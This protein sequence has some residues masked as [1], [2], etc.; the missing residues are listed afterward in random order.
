MTADPIDI[1]SPEDVIEEATRQHAGTAPLDAPWE[2]TDRGGAEWAIAKIRQARRTWDEE[3]CAAHA[4][5]DALEEEIDRLGAFIEA[6]RAEREQ[7]ESFFEGKLTAW[8]RRL[9]AEDGTTS[10]KLT[11]G[12]VKSRAAS[13]RVEVFDAVELAENAVARGHDYATHTPKVDKRKLLAH[14][15]ATGEIP[16]GAD[17]I[18]PTDDDVHYSVEVGDHG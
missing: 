14:I 3:T 12:T 15:K 8:L 17:F 9:R 5:I 11:G 4:S 6:R 13:E 7:A 10:V 18:Q 1:R 16:Y 2:V